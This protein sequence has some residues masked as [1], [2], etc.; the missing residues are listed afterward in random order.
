MLR[1]IPLHFTGRGNMTQRNIKN[2]HQQTCWPLQY[3]DVLIPVFKYPEVKDRGK[4]KMKVP[5]HPSFPPSKT[6][7]K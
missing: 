4:A 7:R 1:H 3:C 5:P 6:S 2:K